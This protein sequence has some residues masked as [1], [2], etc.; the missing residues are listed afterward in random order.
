[1]APWRSPP[2]SLAPS[3]SRGLK[4]T[5]LSRNT[6]TSKRLRDCLF[7]SAILAVCDSVFLVLD[8]I[9]ALLTVLGSLTLFNCAF[10]VAVISRS[11]RA[12]M[13]RTSVA[14]K[15]CKVTHFRWCNWTWAR[16]RLP[17]SSTV[18]CTRSLA[19]ACVWSLAVAAAVDRQLEALAQM[20]PKRKVGLVTF[21]G[22]VTIVG[23]SCLAREPGLQVAERLRLRCASS[24]FVVSS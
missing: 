16:D 8:S 9:R 19:D 17:H 21:N 10:R 7:G 1:M 14:C 15:P 12:R 22:D 24:L 5:Q 3:N 20:F 18:C 13:S 6:G 11:K 2:K 23:A 4:K